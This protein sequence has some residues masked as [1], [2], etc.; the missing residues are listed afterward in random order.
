MCFPPL[1]FINGVW[2]SLEGGAC[3]NVI[4]CEISQPSLMVH[5][6]GTPPTKDAVEDLGCWG[7]CKTRPRAGCC[8]TCKGP[9][10]AWA[11][12]DW[13]AAIAGLKTATRRYEHDGVIDLMFEAFGEQTSGPQGRRTI[14]YRVTMT[15]TPARMAQDLAMLDRILCSL[16]IKGAGKSSRPCPGGVAGRPGPE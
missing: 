10:A 6:Y 11:E 13:S 9:E 7:D 1:P 4:G 2:I 8:N 12:G 14:A 5:A 15:T 16:E 3:E